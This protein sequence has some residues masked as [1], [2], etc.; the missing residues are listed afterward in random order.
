MDQRH[1]NRVW[2]HYTSVVLEKDLRDERDVVAGEQPSGAS[3]ESFRVVKIDLPHRQQRTS[4]T[5]RIWC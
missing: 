4:S 2:K 1:S 5:R 3:V